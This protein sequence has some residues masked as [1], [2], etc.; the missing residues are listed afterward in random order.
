MSMEQENCLI[1]KILNTEC[2]VSADYLSI[3]TEN[4][5]NTQSYACFRL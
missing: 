1:L 2:F 3:K 4:A 5:S